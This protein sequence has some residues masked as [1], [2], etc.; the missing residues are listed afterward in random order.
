MKQ[1][2]SP[3]EAHIP[4]S[5]LP[6]LA[7]FIHEVGILAS[8]PR[9]GLW[10]LGTGEQSVAEHLLRAAY[11]AYALAHYHPE[12]DK[13]RVAMM[14]MVHDLG[15][16]RT[17]DHNYV[18]QKYGRLSEDKAMQD[19]ADTV[20]FGEE[21]RQ[22]YLEERAKETI[23][24]KLVKD[25]DQLEWMATLLHEDAKGNKKARAWAEIAQKRLKTKAGQA[26]GKT[27]L[28]THPDSWWLDL[29]SQWWVDR[30]PG[31]EKVAKK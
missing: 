30:K 3:K 18:H 6:R 25:A 4:A 10:F 17:S 27:L 29:K 13:F 31:T 12:V 23:E 14:A 24:A 20:P 22:L 1:A 19:F 5:D 28:K 9:S 8:T 16:G 15:E 2:K 26:L 11:I 7:N 21:I